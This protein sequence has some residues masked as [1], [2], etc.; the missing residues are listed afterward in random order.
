MNDVFKQFKP[1]VKSRVP[2]ELL[3]AR[4]ELQAHIAL[5]SNKVDRALQMMQS[6]ARKERSLRY[7]EPTSYPRPVLE[8]L[9]QV[10]FQHGKFS[11]AKTAFTEALEQYPDSPRAKRGLAEA[12]AR[13]E[14]KNQRAGL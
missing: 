2:K 6:A 3:V 1:K 14:A 4:E 7:S 8:V 10:A 13:L 11:L 5:L 9:G 12:V